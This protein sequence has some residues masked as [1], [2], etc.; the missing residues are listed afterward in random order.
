M[1]G[2]VFLSGCL[3]GDAQVHQELRALRTELQKAKETNEEFAAKLKEAEE[4]V[5]EA[6]RAA[7]PAP[8]L[9]AEADPAELKKAR[10]EIS[11]L[12]K[13][14]AEAKAAPAPQPAASPSLSAA[15]LKELAK[16]LQADL[17]TKVNELSDQVQAEIP[18]AD[19]QEVTVKRIHPPQEINTAF[20]SAITFTMLDSRRQP[21]PLQFPVQAG[22]DGTWHVPTVADVQRVYA[23]LENG[24]PGA[25][26]PALASAPAPQQAAGSPSAPAA[27]PPSPAGGTFSR[28]PGG[29]IIVDWGDKTQAAAPATPA[30]APAVS[31]TP[32]PAAPMP[33]APAPAP[34]A[35]VPVQPTT[36][37]PVMPVQQDIIIRFD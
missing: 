33:S 6:G 4:K 21:V 17:M 32:T 25:A 29:E 34:V 15:G 11:R 12:E 14:L 23:G 13:A 22:L 2:L 10:E 27:Q 37:K 28:G 7:T 5:R 8:T 19:L 36:P 3:E 18:T 30:P 1:A 24:A 35:P 9:P 26:A 16:Q 20:T 31:A